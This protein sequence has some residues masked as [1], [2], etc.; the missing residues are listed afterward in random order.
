MICTNGREGE[1]LESARHGHFAVEHV[2]G[3]DLHRE[4]LFVELLAQLQIL[5]RV[6]KI[7]HLFVRPVAESAEE[8]GGE[9]FP[10]AFAPVEIDVK[11]VA[12]VELHFDPRTAIRDD[13]EAVEHFAVEMD[14]GLESDTRGA[15]E[16]ANDDAFRAV[17]DKR[18]RRRHERDFAHVDFFFLGPLFFLELESDVER[19]AEGL[20]FTLRFERAQFRLADFVLAEIE[21]RLFVVAL[22]RENFLEHGLE[23]GV[24]PLAR[25]D[26][27]LQ[28][29]D[30]GIELNL[31]Q[32]RWL[33]RLFD[34]AEVDTLY[35]STV[36]HNWCT[37]LQWFKT[38]SDPGCRS[39][40]VRGLRF[41]P[42][43][44]GEK[45]GSKTAVCQRD[46]HRF[47]ANLDICRRERVKNTSGV[48]SQKKGAVNIH[49]LPAGASAF[50]CTPPAAGW[51]II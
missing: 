8:G 14:A 33:N 13:A 4:A 5:D 36:R 45:T 15:M 47:V 25:R 35:C 44:A 39:R 6:E 26:V 16:L 24:L 10:A 49:I 19:G 38:C 51:K 28:K 48:L 50:F 34:F 30:V 1:R 3:E 22:D 21:S 11:Q 32:V 37:N 40:G 23:T 18:A 29:I 7:D 9:E 12:G 27:F 31:D 46:L 17:D 41:F 2:G 20:A 43:I 42:E